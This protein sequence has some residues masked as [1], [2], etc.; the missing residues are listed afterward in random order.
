MCSPPSLGLVFVRE[1]NP[2]PGSVYGRPWSLVSSSTLLHP[3]FDQQLVEYLALNGLFTSVSSSRSL[4]ENAV[5][6]CLLIPNL[7]TKDAIEA[8]LL[9]AKTR[10]VSGYALG[11]HKGSSLSVFAWAVGN[12]L[13]PS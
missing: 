6:S 11:A 1:Y 4:V 13:P 7:V 2:R 12:T 5:Q 10:L 3:I 8:R 9:R